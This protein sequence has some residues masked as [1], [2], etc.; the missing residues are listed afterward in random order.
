MMTTAV[1]TTVADLM[2][3]CAGLQ[4]AITYV[5]AVIRRL[6]SRTPSSNGRTTRNGTAP[7]QIIWVH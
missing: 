4:G 3:L 2:H 7:V 6:H 1:V 5:Y